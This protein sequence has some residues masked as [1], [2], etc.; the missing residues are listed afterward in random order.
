MG[1]SISGNH[2]A[3]EAG[4]VEGGRTVGQEW[5]TCSTGGTYSGPR[6]GT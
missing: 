4:G 2:T 6:V 3:E 5:D 1:A